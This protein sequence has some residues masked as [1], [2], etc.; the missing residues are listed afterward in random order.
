MKT[1]LTR[2]S[3]FLI[4]LMIWSILYYSEVLTPLI[5]APPHKVI[6][7][8][9]L[10]FFQ[11]ALFQ[12]KDGGATIWP[13]LFA[14]LWRVARGLAIGTLIGVPLGILIGTFKRF[15]QAFDSPIAL[16]RAIPVTALSTVFCFLFGYFGDLTKVI[17]VAYAT[18]LLMMVGA[19]EGVRTTMKS[20]YVEAARLDGATSWDLIRYVTGY[21]A[22][23]QI[24]ANIRVSYHVGMIVTVVTEQF[25]V[26]SAYGL[27]SGIY[28]AQYSYRITEVWV[29]ILL[30]GLLG[31]GLDAL[32]KGLRPKLITWE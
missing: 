8:F 4:V 12:M 16:A 24:Y 27:G 13:Y 5:F 32:L 18:S 31:L 28:N 20:E 29:F 7:K 21:L 19:A 15:E 9:A 1:I 2:V 3:V 30:L 26:I 25:G 6:E 17:M 23:P 14:T 22:I 11:N 10:M